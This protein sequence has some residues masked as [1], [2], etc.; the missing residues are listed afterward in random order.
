M[1][2][3]LVQAVGRVAAVGRQAS[4]GVR[5]SIDPLGWSH[6]PALGDSIAVAGCC[7]TV[8]GLTSRGEGVA[9]GA[10]SI[11]DFDAVPQTL[12]MTRLGALRV[13]DRVNLEHAVTA[14]TLMGGHVVQGHIDGVAEVV[15][16]DRGGGGWRVR[17]RLPVGSEGPLSALAVPKGSVCLDGVSLT[18]AEL[19][20]ERHTLGVA[21]I[22]ATLAM[23]TLADLRPG[24]TVNVEMDVMT[25]AIV[26]TVRAYLDTLKLPGRPA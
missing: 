3:G 26:R 21:L 1:F 7:L 13:G 24:D 9:G 15:D 8:A 19:D 5:L 10:G 17:V 11:W 14:S 18:V 6:V 22:P 23:T 12:A 20:A 4:G 2:T 16:V 25:K